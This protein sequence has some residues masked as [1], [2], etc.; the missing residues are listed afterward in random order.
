M[1]K[2]FKYIIVSIFQSIIID[3]K[4]S[5]DSVSKPRDMLN[6]LFWL[7]IIAVI[8]GKIYLVY[9]VLAVYI[10]VYIWKV[11]KQGEWRHKLRQKTKEGIDDEKSG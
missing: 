2:E 9:T 5:V 3:L 7:A 8:A 4:A 11:I 6:A 10:I 1:I